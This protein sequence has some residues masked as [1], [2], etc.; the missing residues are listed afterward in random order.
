MSTF[1]ILAGF[2]LLVIGGELLVRASVGLSFKLKLSKLVIGMTV[3]SFAT[4]A[5]ELIVS[6]QSAFSGH[7]DLAIGNIIGSNIANLALVLGITAL[8]SPLFVD[9][10]FFLI[11]WPKMML[12]SILLYVFLQNDLVLSRVEGGILFTL[13][14]AFILLLISRARKLHMKAPEDVDDSLKEIGNA[15]IFLWLVL[16][17]LALWYGSDL[18]IGGATTIA[19]ELGVSEAVIAATMV[20]FG[21][22]V[23]ELAASVIAAIK[24]E[25]A[26]S[27][28]NLIGSNIFNI[29]SVLGLTALIQPIKVESMEL[30]HNDIFWML[31]IAAIIAPMAFL[32][33]RN[34]LSR[35]EG[36]TLVLAYVVFIYLKFN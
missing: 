8:I 17:G 20:A 1:Y 34:R 14:V 30:L 11:N 31:A 3:V 25:K 23:P 35:L 15:K 24:Q 2:V 6:M 13:L 32:P 26:L 5:P 28:G 33:E 27:L 4:S 9:R 12:A 10:E 19:K 7:T 36:L 16:G 22:S 21:T 18:L 29:G